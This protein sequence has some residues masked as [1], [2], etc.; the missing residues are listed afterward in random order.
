VTYEGRRL[1]AAFLFGA[2]IASWCIAQ[3]I[4]LLCKQMNCW[5]HLV[6]LPLGRPP[7]QD[8]KGDKMSKTASLALAPSTTLFARL[9]SL[10]DR[11]LMAN[12]QIAV[13]NG[14]LPYFGL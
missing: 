11:V 6:C 7:S 2:P 4:M 8:K 3:I 10:I 9:L 12:A 1:P 5:W 14:D 13:R